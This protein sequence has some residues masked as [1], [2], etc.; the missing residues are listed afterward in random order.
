MLSIS[1]CMENS[2]KYRFLLQVV[3]G[4]A[5]IKIFRKPGFWP[6]GVFT[7]Y[8]WLNATKWPKMLQKLIRTISHVSRHTLDTLNHG[9]G[10]LFYCFITLFCA[11]GSLDPV[12]GPWRPPG[13]PGGPLTLSMSSII[14]SHPRSLWVIFDPSG[15]NDSSAYIALFVAKKLSNRPVHSKG[16]RTRVYAHTRVRFF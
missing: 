9:L 3:S 12:G 15:V 5:G 16:L 8:R 6:I 14:V 7:K 13:P 2:K 4:N 10:P 11:E 1:V